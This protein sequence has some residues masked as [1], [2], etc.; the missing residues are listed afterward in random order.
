[1]CLTCGSTG[2]L[3]SQPPTGRARRPIDGFAL[4]VF[5]Y[6]CLHERTPI[7][8][9][10]R[11]R[12][13][14]NSSRGDA[15]ATSRIA[16]KQIR[17]DRATMMKKAKIIIL[18]ATICTRCLLQQISFRISFRPCKRLPRFDWNGCQTPWSGLDASAAR[19]N[20]A[21]HTSAH[22]KLLKALSQSA[23]AHTRT[24]QLARK[25]MLNLTGDHQ[26]GQRWKERA[27]ERFGE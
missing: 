8:A 27:L 21:G 26:F 2:R 25:W 7:S 6:D 9:M 19:I 15:L 18:V 20:R 4:R 24:K 17:N 23:F 10:Y 5:I 13:A 3:Q 12:C 16:R 1:M 11:T 22:R 14:H